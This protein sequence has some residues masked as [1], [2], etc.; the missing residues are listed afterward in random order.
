[1]SERLVAVV[2]LTVV[3]LTRRTFSAPCGF[4]GDE[5]VAAEIYITNSRWKD[6]MGMK[7]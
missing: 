2:K 3:A 1:M 5:V 7:S 4:V 6:K